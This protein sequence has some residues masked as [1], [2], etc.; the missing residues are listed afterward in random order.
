MSINEQIRHYFDDGWY[1]QQIVDWLV[2][3]YGYTPQRARAAVARALR[4]R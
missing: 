2:A 4:G 1:I 3:D